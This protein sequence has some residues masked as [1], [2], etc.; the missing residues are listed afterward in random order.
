MATS[1]LLALAAALTLLAIL[2]GGYL[3]WQE[4]H[5]ASTSYIQELD[6]QAYMDVCLD[7]PERETYDKMAAAF[8]EDP[9]RVS[10]DMLSG[11]LL[12]RAIAIV[13]YIER[14]EKDR[15]SVHR[16]SKNAVIPFSIVDELMEAE[17]LLELEIK[18]VQAEAERLRPGWGRG[19]YAQAYDI[20][21]RQRDHAE[22]EGAS[23]APLPVRKQPSG[24]TATA[25][26]APRPPAAKADAPVNTTAAAATAASARDGPL[27]WSQTSEEVELVI[28]VAASTR[29]KDVSVQFGTQSCSVRVGGAGAMPVVGGRLAHK[30]RADECTWSLVG[31][32]D[33]RTLIVTLFKNQAADWSKLME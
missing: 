20:V 14:I 23:P 7:T 28:A 3:W 31:D 24:A 9:R 1:S 11:A 8:E 17:T 16:L 2:I 10:N 15:P 26:S 27:S 25:T 5:R 30:V 6:D 21:R 18:E 32:G 13:P 22:T 12:R 4:Q 29:P 33:A 19:V